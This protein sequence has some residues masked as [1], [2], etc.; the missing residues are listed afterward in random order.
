VL[1]APDHEARLDDPIFF[2]LLADPGLEQVVPYL[3][4][5]IASEVNAS[6]HSLVRLTRLLQ[7]MFA[8]VLNCTNNLGAYISQALPALL[9]CLLSARIGPPRA[10]FRHACIVYSYHAP[11]S[12]SPRHVNRASAEMVK[13]FFVVFK[14]TLQAQLQDQITGRSASKRQGV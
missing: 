4:A 2:A 12:F 3:V 13:R 10:L 5:H 9:T 6:L 11:F 1:L 8:L 14:K 7:A